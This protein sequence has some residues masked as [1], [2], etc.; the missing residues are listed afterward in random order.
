MAFDSLG[1]TS[2]YAAGRGAYV[3]LVAQEEPI[4]VGLLADE[5]GCQTLAKSL[6]GVD[7]AEEDLAEPDVSDAMCELINIVAGG[8]KRR[9]TPRLSVTM[10]LPIFVAGRPLANP[11][12]EAGARLLRI[13]DVQVCVILL[14]QR[15]EERSVCESGVNLQLVSHGPAKENSA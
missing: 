9:V 3:G 14:T 15:A 6:L 2:D 1:P 10:G 8:L 4:Q 7:P 5:R 13:G 12:Q 11:Q